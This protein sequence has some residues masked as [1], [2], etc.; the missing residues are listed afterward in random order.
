MTCITACHDDDEPN[1]EDYTPP[2]RAKRTVMIYMSGENNLTMNNNERFLK[3]D[4]LEIIEGSKTLTNDQRLFIYVDSLNTN[5]SYAGKP[6]IMEVHGGKTYTRY[7]FD[8]DFYSC[9]PDT[10]RHVIERIINI[11]PADSYGLV[12]WGHATGWCIDQD[13]IASSRSLTRRA[14]G[15]DYGSDSVYQGAKWMNITQMAR[16][17]SGL[18]KLEFIFA[19]CCNMM[20][21]EIGYE[22]RNVTNYLIGSPAEIPG[23]GAPY[24]LIISDLYKSDSQ[25]Y[26]NIIDTYYNYYYDL[27]IGDERLD[28]CSVPLSVID[29][30]HI[31]SL[32][33]ATHDV[34]SRFSEP[35]PQYPDYPSL[36][37]DSIS[38]YWYFD[39]PIMYDMRAFIKAFTPEEVFNQWDQN[40][41]QQA[42]PYYRM[43]KKW[44]TIY[45]SLQSSFQRFSKDISCCGCVSMFI[46]RSVDM[47]YRSSFNYNSTYNNYEWNRVIDWSRF[48]WQ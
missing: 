16:A 35:Y 3:E 18:P 27:Y 9:D 28:K 21:A 48:G 37:S 1:K 29:T 42:V 14:Y 23:N 6:Y 38:F 25:L 4:L 12:L 34:L 2:I 19:D 45:S 11:A 46:P 5:N 13:S 8:N 33:Q 22:L 44:M 36:T 7:Q 30:R 26:R 24:H 43:S 31:E 39:T 47:Y 20:C 41:Y 40:Y 10:F 15:Q 32:A 17:L